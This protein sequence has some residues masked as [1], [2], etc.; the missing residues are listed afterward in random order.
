[1]P[2]SD[3]IQV[4]V[5]FRDQYNK[6]LSVV[7]TESR[8]KR[9]LSI[10]LSSISQSSGGWGEHMVFDAEG[11]LGLLDVLQVRD[12]TTLVDKKDRP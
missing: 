8:G 12:L 5:P 7:V 4:G 6:P 3:F 10:Q 2:K 11:L 9:S 1:M